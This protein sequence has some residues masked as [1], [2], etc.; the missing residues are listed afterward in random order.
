MP[1]IADYDQSGYDYTK[2]WIGRQYE[3]KLEHEL[4]EQWLPIR[5]DHLIDLGGGFGRFMSTYLP[6]FKQA[7]LLD[8]SQANLEV[9]TQG[10]VQLGYSNLKTIRGS[11]YQ[12]PVPNQSFDAA[13]MIRVLHHLEEP[14]QAF[15]EIHRLLKPD[16]ILIIEMANKTNLKA[17]LRATAHRN[18][19]F[20]QDLNPLLISTNPAAK[21]AGI[22]LNYHPEH[23]KKLLTQTG[24]VIEKARSISNLRIPILKKFLPTATLVHIDHLLQPLFTAQQ[25]G[26]SLWFQCRRSA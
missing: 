26:P 1:N 18:Y 2:Y 23:I 20:A 10:A 8:Y 7:T 6:R 9:A 13:I 22:F 25:W 4:L 24:F 19:K 12:I 5:G 15:S 17:I 21:E 14:E 11:V 3:D 16:G